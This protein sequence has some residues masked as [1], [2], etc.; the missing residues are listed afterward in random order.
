MNA[1]T[2][3]THQQIESI[4]ARLKHNTDAMEAYRIILSE[5]YRKG[6]QNK[7]GYKRYSELYERAEKNVNRYR[8]ELGELN[9]RL[10]K[11]GELEIY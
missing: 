5:M 2:T 9:A 3:T 4:A 8:Y 7:I 10:N 6:E 1:T 11:S